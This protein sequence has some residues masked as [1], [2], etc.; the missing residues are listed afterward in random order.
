MCCPEKMHSNSGPR[1]I[2][3]PPISQ[4][5]LIA[6]TSLPSMHSSRLYKCLP[7]E[8]KKRRNVCC[9]LLALVN[10]I[11]IEQSHGRQRSDYCHANR[12]SKLDIFRSSSSPLICLVRIYNMM[13]LRRSIICRKQIYK[14]QRAYAAD[15]LYLMAVLREREKSINRVVGR[16]ASI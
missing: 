3:F 8:E 15:A 16:Y 1:F 4:S 5:I 6:I 13:V 7:K 14:H 2:G 10:Y 9:A 12:N 11:S